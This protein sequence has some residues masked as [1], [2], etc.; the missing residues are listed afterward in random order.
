[1]IRV[2]VSGLKQ[3]RIQL[4]P[5]ASRYLLKVHR[6]NLGA[7]VE[8]FSPEE[9]LI[10]LAEL[11]EAQLPQA[12][13]RVDTLTPSNQLLP[14]LKLIQCVGKNE[15]PEEAVRDATVYGASSVTF[16]LS[17]RSVAKAQGASRM[18]RWRKLSVESARQCQRDSLPSIEA[19]RDL[20]ECLDDPAV[21]EAGLRLMCTWHPQAR[22]LL[23]VLDSVDLRST[24]VV[25]LIGPEGGL[26]EHEVQLALNRSFA[27]ISLGPLVLRT[28]AAT[29]LALSACALSFERQLLSRS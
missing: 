7:K 20:A 9:G 3:G 5:A 19:P 10:G 23:E 11:I 18:D 26:S 25:V 28:E 6:L 22:P 16:A 1:M 17:E 12:V 8:V 2:P 24:S 21:S 13:L 15:K 27:P 14:E 29:S 4:E